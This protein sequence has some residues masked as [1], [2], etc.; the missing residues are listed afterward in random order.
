VWFGVVA[1]I[2]YGCANDPDCM[3]VMDIPYKYFDGCLSGGCSSNLITGV[4]LAGMPRPTLGT[5]KNSHVKW[6]FISSE[7][8]AKWLLYT[9]YLQCVRTLRRFGL[10]DQWMLPNGSLVKMTSS[11]LSLDSKATTPHHHQKR[12]QFK[13]AHAYCLNTPLPHPLTPYRTIGSYA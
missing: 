3:Y 13:V 2:I 9:P 5:R 6:S 8:V 4:L 11:T 1:I 12:W 7:S 10:T